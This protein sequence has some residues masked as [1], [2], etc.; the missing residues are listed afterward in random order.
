M[1]SSSPAAAISLPKPGI[2]VANVDGQPRIRWWRV[3]PFALLC[4]AAFV[5]CVVF[6]AVRV[7]PHPSIAR[8][9]GILATAL[10]VVTVVGL[11]YQ[12]IA[13]EIER[14]RVL[15]GNR[16]P[17]VGLAATMLLIFVAAAVLSLL[18]REYRTFTETRDASFAKERFRLGAGDILRGTGPLGWGGAV[19]PDAVHGGVEIFVFRQSFDN[20]D[21]AKLLQLSKESDLTIPIT[22]LVFMPTQVDAAGLRQLAD[23]PELAQLTYC[24][25][26]STSLNDEMIDAILESLPNLRSLMLSELELTP[27]QLDRIKERYPNLIF[28]NYGWKNRDLLK[29]RQQA[30]NQAK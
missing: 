10:A 23:Y 19:Q 27:T 20:A 8:V 4:A 12:I 7:S 5:I 11:A 25:P 29:K 17:K 16:R 13:I 18:G 21:L 24:A 3:L 6:R 9:E 2:W 30:K 15:S 22:G 14:Q 1:S 28:N 26:K